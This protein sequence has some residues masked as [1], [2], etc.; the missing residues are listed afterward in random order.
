[1]KSWRDFIFLGVSLM[2]PQCGFSSVQ[3]LVGL[4]L[5]ATLSAG[6]LAYFHNRAWWPP[7][8]GAYA[9]VAERILDGEVLNRDV[10]DVHM[11]YVNFA[12]ALAM[13]AFGRD[14]VSLRYPLAF[15]TFL[16]V[17]LIYGLL[18][19][20]GVLL[21]VAGAISMACL[22]FVQFLNPTAHWYCLFLFILLLVVIRFSQRTRWRLVVCGALMMTIFLFRQLTGVF[23]IIGTIAYLLYEADTREHEYI[24]DDRI[25]GWVPRGLL[26]ICAAGLLAYLVTKV[27][28]WGIVF[29]GLWPLATLLL[30]SV[31]L[32]ITNSRSLHLLAQLTVGALISAMPLL[33]YHLIHGT[34]G[35]WLRDTVINAAHVTE[36][37]FVKPKALWMVSLQGLQAMLTRSGFCRDRKWGPVFSTPLPSRAARI[38]RL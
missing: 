11:G 8:D 20:K 38:P 4:A 24:D 3:A 23:V 10:H 18:L 2:K 19:D 21:S 12:N 37:P 5:V 32:S 27:N 6:V 15:M 22:S 30:L 1:M 29:I 25:I 35:H 26:L 17:C 28:P 14:L 7:D 33:A 31:R 16:Q 34:L 36:L 13:A 9:H